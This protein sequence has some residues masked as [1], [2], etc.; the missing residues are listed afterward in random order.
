MSDTPED[1]D[2]EPEDPLETTD[3]TDPKAQR[4]ARNRVKREGQ[5]AESFWRA[6]F[7]N[8]VGRHEMWRLIHEDCHGF[9]PPFACGPNGFPN[10][11]ATWFQAGQYTLGQRLYQRFLRI[12]PEDVL[13]MHQENDP[14]H[15]KP[16]RMRQAARD[17][18][19]IDE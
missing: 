6:V 15:M 14:A 19:D 16:R 8:K 7:A 17:R 12:A 4:R 10:S 11:Q 13:K 9:T 18:G 1:T 5:E 2:D 3:L